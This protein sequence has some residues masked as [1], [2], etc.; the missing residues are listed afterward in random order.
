MGQKTSPEILNVSSFCNVMDPTDF[1]KNTSDCH[2]WSVLS[3]IKWDLTQLFRISLSTNL[4]K[5]NITAITITYKL[6]VNNSS[7]LLDVFCWV[8]TFTTYNEGFCR[9]SFA[10]MWKNI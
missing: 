6:Y 8:N 9:D 1:Q 4:F 3:Y 2:F 10:R 5:V 7:H